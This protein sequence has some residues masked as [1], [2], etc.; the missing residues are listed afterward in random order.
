MNRYYIFILLSIFSIIFI[1]N[2]NKYINMNRYII[3][4]E[5]IFSGLCNRLLGISSCFI[6][7][8]ISERDLFCIIYFP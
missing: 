8:Q 6:L 2:K 3:I 7:S 1:F 4:N 5:I